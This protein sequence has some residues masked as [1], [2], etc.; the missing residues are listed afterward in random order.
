MNFRFLKTIKLAGLSDNT[1][2]MERYLKL[3]SDMEKGNQNEGTKHAKEVGE[4]IFSSLQKS[5]EEGK[6]CSVSNEFGVVDIIVPEK[7]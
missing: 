2:P 4:K 6:S 7:D 5:M 3:I 1:P